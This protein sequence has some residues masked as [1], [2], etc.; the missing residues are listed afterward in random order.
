LADG[1]LETFEV[2]RGGFKTLVMDV[3]TGTKS[4]GDAFRDFALS[5]LQSLLDLAAEILAQEILKMVISLFLPGMGQGSLN[6]LGAGASS[7][8]VSGF[9][10]VRRAQGGPAPNRDSA[11]TLLEPG[12]FV[13]SKTATDFIGRDTLSSMNAA[14]NRRMSNISTV[15]QA[16]RR[17]PDEVNVWVVSP[18]MPRPTGKKDIVAAISQDLLENGQTRRLIKA[19]Q[20]GA[21]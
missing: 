11:L 13:M 18:D 6:G 14:G 17:D 12:E 21:L 9:N 2:A 8:S 1:L 4:M 3:V 16:T 10:A 19:I 15:A 20:V 5:V 7:G